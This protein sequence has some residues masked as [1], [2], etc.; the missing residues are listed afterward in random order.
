MAVARGRTA[1]GESVAQRGLRLAL[2]L[3]VPLHHP[4]VAREVVIVGGDVG[5]ALDAGVGRGRDDALVRVAVHAEHVGVRRRD[6]AD[7]RHDAEAVGE[8][9]AVAVRVHR[10]ATLPRDAVRP[11]IALVGRAAGAADARDRQPAAEGLLADVAADKAAATKDDERR[12]AGVFLQSRGSVR[13]GRCQRL[14]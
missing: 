12:D 6:E 1:G 2:A 14:V 7:A 11:R 5:E 13:N 4:E 8:E 3:E 10:I 9:V